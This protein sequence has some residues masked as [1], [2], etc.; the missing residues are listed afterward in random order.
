MKI[1]KKTDEIDSQ[2]RL[3]KQGGGSIF[4]KFKKKLGSELQ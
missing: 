1:L 3:G 2:E 4:N